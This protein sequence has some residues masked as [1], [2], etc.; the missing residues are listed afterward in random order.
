M[1]SYLLKVRMAD[2]TI[3]ISD[4]M[5]AIIDSCTSLANET[6]VSKREKRTFKVLGRYPN[7]DEKASIL[8]RITSRDACSP[9]RSL[10]TLARKVLENDYMSKILDGHTPN[11]SVFKAELDKLDENYKINKLSDAEIVSE[12]VSVFFDDRKPTS[13]KDL[14]RITA[15]KI[16]EIVLQHINEKQSL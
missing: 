11:G 8:I 13:E 9:T 1:I 14:N 7:D 2:P 3:K 10:S 6:T 16:R 12:V 5:L 15:E 4:K